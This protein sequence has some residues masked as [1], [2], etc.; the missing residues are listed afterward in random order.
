MVFCKNPL[1]WEGTVNSMEQKTRVF[2]QIDV[3]EFHLWTDTYDIQY[4]VSPTLLTTSCR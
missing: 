3:Q 1:V 2:S 4:L